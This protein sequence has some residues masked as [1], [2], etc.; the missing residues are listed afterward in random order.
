[1]LNKELFDRAGKRIVLS[2][3]ISFIPALLQLLF[4][5]YT[6]QLLRLSM[7]IIVS[8][9]YFSCMSFISVRFLRILLIV[10]GVGTLCYIIYQLY[11]STNL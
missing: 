11:L 8:T 10:M 1:V 6:I 7:I 3:I 9:M 2:V 5:A 4:P